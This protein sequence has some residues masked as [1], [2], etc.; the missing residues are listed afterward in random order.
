MVHAPALGSITGAPWPAV[1]GLQHCCVVD[2]CCL[3]NFSF[4]LS[5][6]HS[7]SLMLARYCSKTAGFSFA[8]PCGLRVHEVL[9]LVDYEGAY[10]WVS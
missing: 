3:R 5:T 2:S 6:A 1:L 4:V 10:R 9:Q 8:T 7:S